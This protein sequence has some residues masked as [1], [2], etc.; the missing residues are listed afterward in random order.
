[1]KLRFL[2]LS[3]VVLRSALHQENDRCMWTDSLI[4]FQESK[5]SDFCE[6]IGPLGNFDP[7]ALWAPREM[8][9]L[10]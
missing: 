4:V 5:F 3:C 2:T 8:L 6:L 1:M 9:K 10:L 7:Q